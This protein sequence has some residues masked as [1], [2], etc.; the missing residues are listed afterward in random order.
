MKHGDHYLTPQ[1]AFTRLGIYGGD[2]GLTPDVDPKTYEETASNLGLKLKAQSVARGEDGVNFLARYYSPDVWYG[3]EDSCCDIQRQLAKFH[4]TVA[5]PGNVTPL[6]KLKEKSRSFYLSDR[7]TPVLGELVSK[8]VALHGKLPEVTLKTSLLRSWMV[9]TLGHGEESLQYPNEFG[10]WMVDLLEKQLP[11]FDMQLFTQWLGDVKT[12][13]QCLKPPLC[14]LPPDFKATD[15][16]T[17]VNDD[18]VAPKQPAEPSG[19]LIKNG[20]KNNS[21]KK[22][23]YRPRATPRSKTT[24]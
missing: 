7:N 11:H 21:T 8:V 4:T 24:S 6:D 22:S 10:Y 5:L 9:D 23:K 2:D 3:V 20:V 17:Y 14:H 16:K 12:I 1:E 15:V 19:R 18:V 13:E